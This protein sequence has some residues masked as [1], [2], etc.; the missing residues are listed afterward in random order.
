MKDVKYKSP[1][2]YINLKA[3]N[4]SHGKT[5]GT[6]NGHRA[7][8]FHRVQEWEITEGWN[9]ATNNNKRKEDDWG[10]DVVVVGQLPDISIDLKRV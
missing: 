10:I 2:S 6:S 1:L 7:P 3:N 4:V 5:E 9:F 8:E